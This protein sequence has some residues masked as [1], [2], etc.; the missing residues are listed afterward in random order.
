MSVSV[1]RLMTPPMG[2]HAAGAHHAIAG[3]ES[4]HERVVALLHTF[5]GLAEGEITRFVGRSEQAKDLSMQRAE[6]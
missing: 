1:E 3:L 5:R 4:L 6:A 2:I